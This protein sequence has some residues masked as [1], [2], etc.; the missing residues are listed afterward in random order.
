MRNSCYASFNDNE[1][2]KAGNYLR[3]MRIKAA[4]R[5][6]QGAITGPPAWRDVRWQHWEVTNEQNKQLP[7]DI[8]AQTNDCVYLPGFS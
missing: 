6:E 4:V 8:C 3:A 1:K 2:G 5:D 7:V